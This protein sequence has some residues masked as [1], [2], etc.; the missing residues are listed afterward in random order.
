MTLRKKHVLSLSWGFL[1]LFFSCSSD[2]SGQ[3]VTEK[4]ETVVRINNPPLINRFISD[5]DT[6][7]VGGTMVCKCRAEDPDQDSLTY[8][9]GAFRLSDH[10]VRKDA[11]VIYQ[12]S[13]GLFVSSGNE[14]VWHAPRIDG[15]Y[16]VLCKVAD[17]A[18]FETVAEQRV[19]VT[20]KGC[21]YAKTDQIEY[22]LSDTIHYTIGNELNDRAYF[23]D[24]ACNAMS[25]LEEKTKAG[26]KDITGPYAC[27]AIC[28][29]VPLDPGETYSFMP[30]FVPETYGIY[31]LRFEYWFMEER[32]IN[33][34]YTN[35]FDIVPAE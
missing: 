10:P 31:R 35:E 9:W 21:L 7:P 4:D 14:A 11:T 24:C 32:I 33:S 6:L 26:W 13:R 16:L 25:F 2:Y 19:T 28:G 12:R 30:F 8:T 3:P 27:A 17:R 1:I 23:K 20:L 5:S 18:G 22:T 34:L 29:H 15:N